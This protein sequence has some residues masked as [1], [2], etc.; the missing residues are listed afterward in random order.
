LKA[1]QS[2]QARSKK[3]LS[4]LFKPLHDLVIDVVK[5][6]E[7]FLDILILLTSTS[8]CLWIRKRKKFFIFLFFL[9]KMPIL[10]NFLPKKWLHDFH[11]RGQELNFNSISCSQDVKLVKLYLRMC[12][13]K[14]LVFPPFSYHPTSTL[15]Q[16]E[17]SYVWHP[18]DEIQQ[19]LGRC[20]DF[21]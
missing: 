3:I 8:S 7:F 15:C 5:N 19:H 9:F 17:C 21:N 1:F 16:S 18:F 11:F 10:S 13:I 14:I 6:F 2:N 20:A 4:S 12:L